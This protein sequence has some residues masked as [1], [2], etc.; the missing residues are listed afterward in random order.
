MYN[1]NNMIYTY[2]CT[3]IHKY[4]RTKK[5]IHIHVNLDVI[6]STVI[7]SY[8]VAL[9]VFS[10]DLGCKAWT[11]GTMVGAPV[12]SKQDSL[13]EMQVVVV[14]LDNE[15]FREILDKAYLQITCST[16]LDLR[17]VLKFGRFHR[18]H[19]LENTTKSHR[20][21]HDIHWFMFWFHYRIR[22]MATLTCVGFA[23]TSCRRVRHASSHAQDRSETDSN[24]GA[25]GPQSFRI[26]ALLLGA[27]PALRDYFFWVILCMA[28]GLFKLIARLLLEVLL[29]TQLSSWGW[30]VAPLGKSSKWPRRARD[31]SLPWKSWGKIRDL[32]EK[33]IHLHEKI[34]YLHRPRPTYLY[35]W[36]NASKYSKL[37]LMPTLQQLLPASHGEQSPQPNGPPTPNNFLFYFFKEV[38]FDGEPVKPSTSSHYFGDVSLLYIYISICISLFFWKKQRPSWMTFPKNV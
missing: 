24:R 28:A 12:T 36:Q 37:Q 35:C 3:I 19:F 1:I 38:L 13:C 20:Y 31:N 10:L 5:Y 18:F 23:T 22:W 7:Q 26:L 21:S 4:T 11:V 2:I 30:A 8:P 29:W 6:F 25:V 9:E 27:A 33:I 17:L 14:G 15:S 16:F 32:A 34:I